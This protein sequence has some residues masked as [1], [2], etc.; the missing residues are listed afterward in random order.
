[1]RLIIFFLII[2][3]SIKNV[4]NAS[5]QNKILVNIGNNQIITSYELK[6]RIKTIL[7]LN[8]KEL[9]QENVNRTKKEALN[10]LINFKLKKEEVLKFKISTNKKSVSEYLDNI[11]SSYNTDI[12]GFKRIFVNNDIDYGL[13]I[14]GI[15]TEFAWQQL[16]VN[17]YREKIIVNEKE[18]DK[19]LNKTFKNQKKSEEYKLAE[20]EVFLE[21]NSADKKKIEEIKNQ[22]SKIGFEDAAI[23]FSNSLSALEGGNLG[24]IASQALSNIILN[25]VKQM[26][27]GDVSEPIIKSETA[28]FIKLLDK[29][30]IEFSDIN[31]KRMKNQIV[32]QRKNELLNLFSNSYLSKIKNNTLIQYN[33]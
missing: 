10:F 16:I 8:N 2:V 21:N 32:S 24:W 26:N 25:T 27:T 18:I 20:I 19:E 30:K 13:F 29:R 7:I 28:L 17:S 14:D 12:D 15:E 22:I 31:L 5:I 3:L 33:E 9:N 11:S 6:N 1:M 23:K 4:S